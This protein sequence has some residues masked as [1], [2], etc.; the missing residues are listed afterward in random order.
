MSGH[1]ARL[2]RQETNT[3]FWREKSYFKANTWKT[4]KALGCR[5]IG[6]EDGR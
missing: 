3:E 2:G 5:Q 1:V 6:C 4:R